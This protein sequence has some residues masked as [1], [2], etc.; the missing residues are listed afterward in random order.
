MVAEQIRSEYVVALYHN[1]DG[2]FDPDHSE[3]LL[4]ADHDEAICKANKWVIG[5]LISEPSWLHVTLDGVG[6]FTKKI[7]LS[8]AR[9][10]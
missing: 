10:T 9:P 8:N 3:R 5:M 6:I 4:A 7:R 1:K 2:E